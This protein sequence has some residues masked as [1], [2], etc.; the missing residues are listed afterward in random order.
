MVHAE[1]DLTALP[2][3]TAR[4]NWPECNARLVFQRIVPGRSGVEH[5]TLRCTRCG[6]IHQ[7]TVEHSARSRPT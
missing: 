4:S 1:A 5:W 7:V 3:A 2:R 6:H